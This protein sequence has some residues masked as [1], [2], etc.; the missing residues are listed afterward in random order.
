MFQYKMIIF[1]KPYKMACMFL[2][3]GNLFIFG[4]QKDPLTNL[5]GILFLSDTLCCNGQLF[6]VLNY[7]IKV[8]FYQ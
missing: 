6:V 1:Y 5:Y 2:K 8:I 4:F 3:Y 7:F